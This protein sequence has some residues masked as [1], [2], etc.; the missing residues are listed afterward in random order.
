[1]HFNGISAPSYLFRGVVSNAKPN[2]RA[3]GDVLKFQI[4]GIISATQQ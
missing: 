1:M 4:E 3:H 2:T